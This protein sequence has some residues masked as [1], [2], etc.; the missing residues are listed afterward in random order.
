MKERLQTLIT[1]YSSEKISDQLMENPLAVTLRNPWTLGLYESRR[2]KPLSR[3]EVVGFPL[4]TL[5][6]ALRKLNIL[7]KFSAFCRKCGQK[8]HMNFHGSLSC[9]CLDTG[10]GKTLLKLTELPFIT[11]LKLENGPLP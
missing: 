8:K 2:T 5:T 10:M 11:T 6:D 3:E 1:T 7:E 9:S 4:S